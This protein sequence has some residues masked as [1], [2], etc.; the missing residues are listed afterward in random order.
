MPRIDRTRVSRRAMLLATVGGAGALLMQP[1]SVSG[2]APAAAS[3]APWNAAEDKA[4]RQKAD[5]WMTGLALPPR[6]VNAPSSP[7]PTLSIQ[8]TGWWPTPMVVSTGYWTVAGA[9]V[10][11]T[12]NWLSAHPTRDLIVPTQNVLSEDDDVDMV[13]VG[14]VP[15][16][17]AL[18]GIA[19]TVAKMSDGVAIRAEIGVI[20]ESASRP[21]AE[22][23]AYL[24]GP[25]QG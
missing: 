22:R 23:G 11:G 16:R 18:E 15:Y 24:G 25:G 13:S 3:D 5:A 12:A 6:A 20:P 7:S 14:N 8:H 19:Y 10:A 17:D 9:T 4:A 21:T 2:A 1:L